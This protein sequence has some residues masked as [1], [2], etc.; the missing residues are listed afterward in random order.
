MILSSNLFHGVVR[1]RPPQ[2]LGHG[3]SYS[4]HSL[5]GQ[6][7][8]LCRCWPGVWDQTAWGLGKGRASEGRDWREKHRV[9]KVGGSPCCQ[10]HKLLFLPCDSQC[11]MLRTCVRGPWAGAD[12]A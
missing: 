8:L 1:T 4:R 11:L 2:T 10:G 6:G 5:P 7:K 12:R 9:W 3:S